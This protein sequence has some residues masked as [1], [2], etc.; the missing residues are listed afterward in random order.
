MNWKVNKHTSTKLEVKEAE[1]KHFTWN[2]PYMHNCNI[3]ICEEKMF[4]WN[5][6]WNKKARL[7]RYTYITVVNNMVTAWASSG[8]IAFPY[9]FTTCSR[10][11]LYFGC[12]STFVHQ[13]RWS[14]YT[15]R[16]TILTVWDHASLQKINHNKQMV[17]KLRSK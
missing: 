7:K 8:R 11:T 14:A 6:L 3:Y 15:S 1:D 12:N 9:N 16:N 2:K 17:Q 13:P 4:L 10:G 5:I